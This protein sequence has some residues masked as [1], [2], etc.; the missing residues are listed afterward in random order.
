MASDAGSSRRPHGPI[1]GGQESCSIPHLQLE[2]LATQGYLPDSDMA[3]TRL[4]LTSMNGQA[5]R[6]SL[7]PKQG[8]TGMLCSLPPPWP[9]ISY[10]SLSS[11]FARILWATTPPPHPNSIIYIVG[12]VPFTKCTWMR[13]TLRAM[14]EVLMPDACSRGGKLHEVGE[15]EVC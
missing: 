15:A 12:F 10:S 7:I 6:K 11:G 3:S 1:K 9:R 5:R 8:R 4:G 2:R 14:G 13:G